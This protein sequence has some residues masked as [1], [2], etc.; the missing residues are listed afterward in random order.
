MQTCKVVK[1]KKAVVE[2]FLNLK[3]TVYSV[4]INIF[5]VLM[6]S[7]RAKQLLSTDWSYIT[8]LSFV[9]LSTV[10]IKKGSHKR[11]ATLT[12]LE[13]VW[14]LWSFK[15]FFWSELYWWAL[16]E[17][18]SCCLQIDRILRSF[19][20]LSWALCWSRRVATCDMQRSQL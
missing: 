17:R 14:A 2:T 19:T 1:L 12:T 13:V 4:L 3:M 11:Y 9:K 5:T 6:S 20:L 18:N 15:I 7:Q 16:Q 8:L 10:L